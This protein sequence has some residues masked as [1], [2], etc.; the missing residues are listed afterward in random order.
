MPAI[1]ELE[2]RDDTSIGSACWLN[3][4]SVLIF[5]GAPA[6]LVPSV[7]IHADCWR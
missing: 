1:L 4:M 3:E 5:P 7:G 6:I 2:S